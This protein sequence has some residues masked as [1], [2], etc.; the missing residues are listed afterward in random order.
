MRVSEGLQPTWVA[1]AAVA[2]ANTHDEVMN[3][4]CRSGR[5]ALAREQGGRVWAYIGLGSAC[6]A[7]VAQK[8]GPDFI[9]DGTDEPKQLALRA[10]RNGQSAA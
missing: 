7:V 8:D 1:A 2:L 10:R 5:D 3:F 9:C 4:G 6:V